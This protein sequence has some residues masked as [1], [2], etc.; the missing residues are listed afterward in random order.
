M[1]VK[2]GSLRKI[3]QRDDLIA[4]FENRLKMG[5]KTYEIINHAELVNII[6]PTDGDPWD[7]VIPGYECS[8]CI[9][10]NFKI[11][12]VMKILFV[13]GGN[14]KIFVRVNVPG[15]QEDLAEQ[16]MKKFKREYERLN[17]LKTHWV[18]F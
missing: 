9:Y 3:L 13:E 7:L 18:F 15:Y 4:V 6:N 8:L 14:H 2:F 16:Q 11:K 12:E 17:S 10:K 5:Y 1:E